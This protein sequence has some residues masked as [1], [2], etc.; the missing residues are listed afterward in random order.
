M[1]VA[2]SAEREKCHGANDAVT[3]CGRPAVRPR[4]DH[5]WGKRFTSLLAGE[6]SPATQGRLLKMVDNPM[7][8]V[9]TNALIDLINDG[10]NPLTGQVRQASDRPS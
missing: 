6:A 2:V 7:G 9:V 10:R 8:K 1:F 4:G 3:A 5:S